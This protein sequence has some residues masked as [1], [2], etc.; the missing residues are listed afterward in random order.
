MKKIVAGFFVSLVLLS[1][2][3]VF[4]GDAAS[5]DKLDQILKKQDEILKELAD[6]KSELEIVKVRATLR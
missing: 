5:G 3:P 4:A 2:V 6:I 1:A